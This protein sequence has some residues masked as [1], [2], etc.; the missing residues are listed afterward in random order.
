MSRSGRSRWIGMGA[1]PDGKPRPPGTKPASSSLPPGV[2][3]AGSFIPRAFTRAASSE[4][5]AFEDLE[6]AVYCRLAEA[7]PEADPA[8]LEAP[9]R[10]QAR[11]IWE[12]R[13][14]LG[15]P[16]D[17]D[18]L[19]ESF[20]RHFEPEQKALDEK[21]LARILQR[22]RIPEAFL[23]ARLGDFCPAIAGPS[24]EML[25]DD[26]AGL[27]L[28]GP[29]GTGKSHLAAAVVAEIARLQVKDNPVIL[30]ANVP[31]FF[32]EIQGTYGRREGK[33][34][35]EVISDASVADWLVLDDLGAEKKGDWS[36][37]TLYVLINSRLESGR[38]TIV[39]TNEP[40]GAIDTGS[41]RIASRLKA[42]ARL[43]LTGR[44]R[45]DRAAEERK[46][47]FA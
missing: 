24:L 17:A 1:R 3:R 42:F 9:A 8:E 35:Q 15:N 11:V 13:F 44:D 34:A 25:Q 10:R 31:A 21:R 45:R 40:P 7:R 19:V 29:W 38:K 43:V 32:L 46:D 27:L 2:S 41:G 14:E 18:A 16:L 5:L 23:E 30:W 33:T 36:W 28:M 26:A 6:A 22:A 12:R 20:R 4:M 47:L 39:T 37:S